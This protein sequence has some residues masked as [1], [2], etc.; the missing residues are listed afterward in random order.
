MS[1]AGLASIGCSGRPTSSL[2]PSRPP[3]PSVSATAATAPRSPRSISARRSAA[4]G[5]SAACATASTITPASAPWRSS[6][7]KQPHQEALLAGGRAPEQRRERL[8][9]GALGAGAGQRADPLEARVDLRDGQRRLL[10]GRRCVAQR[11]V[12]DADLALAQL[13]REE[14]HAG[15]DLAGV[16]PAQGLGERGDLAQPGGGGGDGLRGLHEAG[17]QHAAHRDAWPR[18]A[19]PD[20]ALSIPSWPPPSPARTTGSRP[21]SRASSGQ[22]TCAPT[23]AR[24]P[25]SAPTRRR[26]IAARP[27]VVAWPGSARGGRR[28]PAARHRAARARRPA[29]RRHEPRRRR[30]C[31][32]AASCS[33]SPAWTSCSSS[34]PRTSWRSASPGVGHGDAERGRR[35]RRPALPAGPGQPHDLDDR[36]QRR[37][38]R[39]RPARPEVRRHARLRARRAGRAARP[40]S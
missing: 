4:R 29:R 12:A 39:G 10:G 28:G 1:G 27:A 15:L 9:P 17:E 7:L 21:T 6:P 38:L 16:Q 30:P 37:H 18:A 24:W 3:T 11:R 22:T 33:C 5:T 31:P 23:P 2:K 20:R 32:T 40:A 8:A 14:R 34:T 13:A 25:P 36:R 35:R 19:R 26:C